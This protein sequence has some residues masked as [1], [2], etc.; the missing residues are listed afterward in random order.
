MCEQLKAT[1]MRFTRHIDAV[2]N[3]LS[4]DIRQLSKDLEPLIA[5]YQQRQG[6]KQ[7]ASWVPTLLQTIV[8]VIA[9]ISAIKFGITP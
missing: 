5:D 4:K 9:I 3:D 8:L 2:K 6:Q 7:V 1:D